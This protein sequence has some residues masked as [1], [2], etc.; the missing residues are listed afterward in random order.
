M[1]GEAE[2][3]VDIPVCLPENF[4]GTEAGFLIDKHPGSGSQCE[5]GSGCNMLDCMTC[6]RKERYGME[7]VLYVAYTSTI[8]ISPLLSVNFSS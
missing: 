8:S 4:G 6:V 5:E 7:V 2:V 1:R 3:C